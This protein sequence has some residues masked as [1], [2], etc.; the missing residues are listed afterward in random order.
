MDVIIDLV[1][2]ICY[3]EEIEIGE[4]EIQVEFD[5]SRFENQEKTQQRIEREV[6]KGITSK[7]EYRMKVYNEEEEVAKQKIADIKANDPSLD[8][9]VGGAE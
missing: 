6:D 4:N 5:Y 8:D 2:S 7:V 9:L 1:K 3:L